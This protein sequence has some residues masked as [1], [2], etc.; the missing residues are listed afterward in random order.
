[1]TYKFRGNFTRLL[2]AGLTLVSMTTLAQQEMEGRKG[3][4]LLLRSDS[5]LPRLPATTQHKPFPIYN[6]HRK[7]LPFP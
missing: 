5:Y 7:P 3:S 2:F 1:M 4:S 6:P